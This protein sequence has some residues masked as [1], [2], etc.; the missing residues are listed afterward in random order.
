MNASKNS[1]PAVASH[2]PHPRAPSQ[3]VA[4]AGRE[5]RLIRA[6]ENLAD[7][8]AVDERGQEIGVAA[9]GDADAALVLAG[10]AETGVGPQADRV[11]AG[12]QL[13][14]QDL[15]AIGQGAPAAGVGRLAGLQTTPP[16]R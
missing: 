2:G 4:P 9:V 16:A 13:Q 10:R 15:N 7:Q 12:G 3:L 14:P 5:G 1:A 11:L 6:G 8:P